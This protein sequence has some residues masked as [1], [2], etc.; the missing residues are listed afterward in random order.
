MNYSPL[1]KWNNSQYNPQLDWW[2][3][4]HHF[5]SL[6]VKDALLCPI[7]T[8]MNDS[9]QSRVNS[10]SEP[11]F[12]TSCGVQTD[13]HAFWA[14]WVCCNRDRSVAELLLQAQPDITNFWFQVH[15]AAPG[16]KSSW[17]NCS[18]IQQTNNARPG[19]WTEVAVREKP[20]MTGRGEHFHFPS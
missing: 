16:L 9:F 13:T 19:Q 6:G 14:K 7:G 12:S 4:H 8:L 20:H 10:H 18:C 15:N 3:E 11:I 1:V 2:G 17:Q 5:P